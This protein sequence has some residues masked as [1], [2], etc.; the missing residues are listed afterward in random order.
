MNVGDYVLCN[1]SHVVDRFKGAVGR[2][3]GIE[4]GIVSIVFLDRYDQSCWLR[5]CLPLSSLLKELI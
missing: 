3:K 5:D 1:S 2:I 4:N